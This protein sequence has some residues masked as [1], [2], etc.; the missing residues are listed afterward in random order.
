MDF[1]ESEFEIKRGFQLLGEA[2][3]GKLLPRE[4]GPPSYGTADEFMFMNYDDL[5]QRVFKHR[6][7]KNYVFLTKDNELVIPSDG[8]PWHR[9]TF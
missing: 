9:G 6:H 4:G 8:S 1:P 3:R 7:T 2:L 5:G